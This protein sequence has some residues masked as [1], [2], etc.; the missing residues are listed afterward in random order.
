MAAVGRPRGAAPVVAA[1]CALT[2]IIFDKK[3]LDGSRSGR[4]RGQ[5]R[6]DLN[7]AFIKT[8]IPN[9]LSGLIA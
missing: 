1:A 5:P 6:Q 7:A 3:G 8:F 9:A 2:S 4:S